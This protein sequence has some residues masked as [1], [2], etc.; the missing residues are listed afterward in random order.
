MPGFDYTFVREVPAEH[1]CPICDCT[2]ARIS[3]N[4]MRPQIL[5]TVLGDFYRKVTL[6]DIAIVTDFK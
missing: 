5:Q 2:D 4:Q 3:A 1:I 6:V